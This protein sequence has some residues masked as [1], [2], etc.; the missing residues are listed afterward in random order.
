MK[1]KMTHDDQGRP[2]AVPETND[3]RAALFARFLEMDVVDPTYVDALNEA[4]HDRK[5]AARRRAAR[6]FSGNAHSVAIGTKRTLILSHVKPRTGPDAIA[7]PTADF[8]T[9][10]HRWNRLISA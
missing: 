9:L 8:L 2:R 1:V 10:L 4:A 3:S 6:H 7:V 5:T